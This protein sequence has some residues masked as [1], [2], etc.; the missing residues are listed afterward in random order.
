MAYTAAKH[1]V[2]GITKTAA[3]EGRAYRIACGQLDIGN[4]DTAMARRARRGALQADGHVRREPVMD[5]E[6]VAQ[7][8][9]H[10]AGLPPDTNV[11]SVTMLATEMPFVGRG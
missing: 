9:A 5:V 8:V 6:H 2:T 7:L 4:A 3:L 1:A 11:L 10:I